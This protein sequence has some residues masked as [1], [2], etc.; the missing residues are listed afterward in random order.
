DTIAFQGLGEDEFG[1]TAIPNLQIDYAMR[2]THVPVGFW[3][4][5]NVNQNAIFTE[6][7]IDELA[8]AAGKDPLEFRRGLM[9]RAPKHRAVLNAAAAKAGWGTPAPAGIY[10]GLSQ[11]CS[12]GSY[13]AAV[14][15]VSVSDKGKL[16]IHRIV[17]A[18]DPGYAVNP[19]MIA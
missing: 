18:V 11:F 8:H 17:C 10:R 1:Y 19:Y 5:V 9:S 7:F 12:Y 6:C 3:R 13:V 14:A 2:N 4:G 15:E 16:K